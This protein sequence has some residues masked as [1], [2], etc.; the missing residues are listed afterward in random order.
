M[1]SSCPHNSAKCPK[2]ALG[3]LPSVFGVLTKGVFGIVGQAAHKWVQKTN[4]IRKGDYMDHGESSLGLFSEKVDARM[5]ELGMDIGALSKEVD[6]TYEHTRKI[7][8]GLANP[9]KLLLRAICRTLDLDFDHEL[10][11]S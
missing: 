4:R 2:P 10:S 1:G 7:V 3:D 5:K 9:S 11:T 6:T 8:R